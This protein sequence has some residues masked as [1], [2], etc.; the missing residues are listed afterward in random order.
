MGV[1]KFFLTKHYDISGTEKVPIVKN[2]LE[3]ERLQLTLT[4]TWV[5]Q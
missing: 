4:L 1:T 3:R 2:W 5:E